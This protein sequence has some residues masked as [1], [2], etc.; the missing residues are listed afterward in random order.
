MIRPTGYLPGRD[1]DVD[2]PGSQPDR[3]TITAH[4][5]VLQIRQ[6]F[7]SRSPTF[8]LSLQLFILFSSL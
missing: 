5:L 1:T 8:C 3:P 6:M 7:S 2:I 4:C